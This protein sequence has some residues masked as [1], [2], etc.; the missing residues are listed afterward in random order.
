MAEFRFPVTALWWRSLFVQ[1]AWNSERM[2]NLGLTMMMAPVVEQLRGT[3]TAGRLA[4]RKYLDFF[5]THPYFVSLLVGVFSRI[6]AEKGDD[7]SAVAAVKQESDRLLGP[8][9]AAGGAWF[10][11]GLRPL[12]GLIG[13]CWVQLAPPALKWWGALLAV[14]GYNL[15][16]LHIRRFGL[17]AGWHEG[18]A[19]IRTYLRGFRE[20]LGTL[21]RVGLLLLGALLVY[22]P[23]ALVTTTFAG[24]LPQFTESEFLHWVLG[25]WL[26]FAAYLFALVRRLGV[27]RILFITAA[28]SVM[29][30]WG[31]ALWGN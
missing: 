31:G 16:H 8:L 29:A 19:A 28:V 4:L 3:G 27:T 24:Q 2:L 12:W 10:W 22:L 7:A 20:R 15:S 17:L 1:V 25:A 13:I 9:A 5:N 21:R 14:L 6:E 23:D 30:G 26:L 11:E 18:E